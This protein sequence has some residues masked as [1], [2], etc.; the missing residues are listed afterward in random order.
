MKLY[1]FLN[2]VFS[3]SYQ[4]FEKNLGKNTEKFQ[5]G[6][7]NF[8]AVGCNRCGIRTAIKLKARIPR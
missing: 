6:D 4:W 2:Y 1:F 8:E 7:G 5:R 3:K